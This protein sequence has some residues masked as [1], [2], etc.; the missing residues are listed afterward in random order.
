MYLDLAGI[1]GDAW[2]ALKVGLCQVEW[3]MGSGQ[4][5]PLPSRLGGMVE[6]RELPQRGQGQSPGRKNGFW[7][8]CRPQNAPVCTYMTKI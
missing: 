4:G 1:S 3:S 7:R 6:R 5:C 2:R 8:I